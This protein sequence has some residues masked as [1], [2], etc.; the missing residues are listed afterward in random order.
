MGKLSH[1]RHYMAGMQLPLGESG[2]DIMGTEAAAG[3]GGIRLGI[4]GIGT[5]DGSGVEPTLETQ[6]TLASDLP[7]PSSPCLLP[8]HLGCH[9]KRPGLGVER[10]HHHFKGLGLRHGARPASSPTSCLKKGRNSLWS[11]P[12]MYPVNLW[13]CM[14][15]PASLFP[16]HTDCGPHPSPNST[17]PHPPMVGQCT[18]ENMPS[19]LHNANKTSPRP[20]PSHKGQL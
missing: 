4:T 8:L 5:E 19:Y 13:E 1:S 16:S 18:Q 7:L 9:R 11:W 10:L 20:D 3:S 12:H 14:E 15:L 17:T 6:S 2:L